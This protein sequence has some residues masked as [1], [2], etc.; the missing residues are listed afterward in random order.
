MTAKPVVIWS[1]ADDSG[2]TFTIN[3]SEALAGPNRGHVASVGL[4]STVTSIS[5]DGPCQGQISAGFQTGPQVGMSRQQVA[6]VHMLAEQSGILQIHAWKDF[7]ISG[8]PDPYDEFNLNIAAIG[9]GN[10]TARPVT[11]L[12]L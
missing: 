8:S 11:V 6:Q 9:F 1:T 2:V 10:N 3:G 4:Y 5:T 12:L 7:G